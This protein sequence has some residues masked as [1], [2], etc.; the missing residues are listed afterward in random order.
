MCYVEVTWSYCG[1]QCSVLEEFTL[2]TAFISMC[3]PWQSLK[4]FSHAVSFFYP[5]GQICSRKKYQNKILH[6]EFRRVKPRHRLGVLTSWR[7][8]GMLTYLACQATVL[9]TNGTSVFPMW[10]PFSDH[11]FMFWGL[12]AG[13]PMA[14]SAETSTRLFWSR[15]RYLG[16]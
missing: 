10:S 13:K 6:Q 15:S 14:D 4:D 8:S 9:V 5:R 11:L 16:T 2:Y 12:V 7:G 3:L 1:D